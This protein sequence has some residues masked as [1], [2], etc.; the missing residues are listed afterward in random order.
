MPPPLTRENF[1]TLLG[2]ISVTY[3]VVPLALI[4][5]PCGFLNPCKRKKYVFQFCKLYF[6]EMRGEVTQARQDRPWSTDVGNSIM[7]MTE[8]LNTTNNVCVRVADIS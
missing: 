7:K 8:L 6:I 1:H 3:I 5:M 4:A 2:P